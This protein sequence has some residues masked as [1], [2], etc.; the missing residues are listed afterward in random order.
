MADQSPP[1]LKATM[2]GYESSSPIP[3]SS[4][5]NAKPSSSAGEADENDEASNTLKMSSPVFILYKDN[6]IVDAAARQAMSPDLVNRLV[7][8]TISNMRS[9]CQSLQSPREST[10]NEI[11]EMAKTLCKSTLACRVE[12]KLNKVLQSST[13]NKLLS[14]SSHQINVLIH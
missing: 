14:S 4:S 1:F 11:E 8:N 6:E 10:K 13:K 9:S 5:S 2:P 12:M 7:R 3:L